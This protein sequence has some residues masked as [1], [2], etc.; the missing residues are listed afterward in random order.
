[1]IARLLDRSQQ[2]WFSATAHFDYSL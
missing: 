1:M 2:W